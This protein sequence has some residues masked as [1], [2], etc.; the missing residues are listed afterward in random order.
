MRVEQR[1]NRACTRQRGD[2]FQHGVGTCGRSAINE[3]NAIS[4]S[5]GDDVRFSR[6][7]H[8]EQIVAQFEGVIALRQRDAGHAQNESGSTADRSLQYLPTCMIN[9]GF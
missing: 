2:R 3:H 4:A 1:P 7:S 5:F 8:D 6:D 9:H